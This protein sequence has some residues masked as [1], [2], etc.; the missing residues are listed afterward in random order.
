VTF[1]I[2][3]ELVIDAHATIGEGPA[4]DRVNERLLWTDI[5]SGTVYAASCA[6]GGM[7]RNDV[8]WRHDG[9][10]SAVVP[11][12]RSSLVVTT[13]SEILA[14]HPDGRTAPIGRVDIDSNLLRFNDGKCDPQGRLWIGT[15]SLDGRSGAGA[16][17]YR[18]DPDHTIHTMVN[19]VA[20]SNGLGWSMDGRKLYYIDTPTLGIDVFDYH[21][22]D[23]S[24]DGRRR[25]I[26]LLKG[27]GR[28][29]GLT[30]DDEGCIWV[31]LFMGGQVRRY[32]PK[33]Y[34][35]LVVTIPA[36]QATSCCFGGEDGRDL[37]ITSAAARLPDWRLTAAGFTS[38]A[39]ERAVTAP[40]AGGV[41]VCRP[42]VSGPA[43]VPFSG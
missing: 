33:G 14:L 32:S 8:V 34:L 4:W 31:A 7:W 20:I 26:T 12:T 19:G 23:G 24:I 39:G 28:P 22:E 40:G 42:G 18:F 9:P 35:L 30:I 10:V 25:L 38:E 15:Q 11:A 3:A 1:T 37:F 36:P 29:D 43:A 13:R 41:F 5:P 17:L 2:S 16:A 21:P 27:E 6:N